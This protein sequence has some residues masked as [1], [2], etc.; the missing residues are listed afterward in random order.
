MIFDTQ[1]WW[2]NPEQY[3]H[4][5]IVD[6]DRLYCSPSF[7]LDLPGV[8]ELL[9]D[10]IEDL[11][12]PPSKILEIGCSCG[13]NMLELHK[14]GYAV[15]GIEINP[16]ALDVAFEPIAEFIEIQSIEDYLTNTKENFDVILSSNVLMHI[17][18]SNEWVFEKLAS[19]TK[20]LV[21]LEREAFSSHVYKWARNYQEVFENLGMTQ[22]LGRPCGLDSLPPTVNLRT[23]I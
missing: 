18:P 15:K 19:R 23:F 2:R 6:L 8:S 16:S 5:L 10:T 20:Y 13:R 7:Y 3:V 14:R 12:V 17:P 22:L 1:A 21:I 11:V 4:R 9:A